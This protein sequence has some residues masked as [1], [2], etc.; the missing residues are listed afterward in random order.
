MPQLD[1]SSFSS[2]LFWLTLSFVVL[3]VVLAR[4]LLPRVQSVF[5]L[6]KQTIEGDI[7]HAEDMESEASRVRD[8]YEK[9]LAQARDKSKT[10]IADTKASI[11]ATSSEKQA[12]IDLIIE[13][14]MTESEAGI[15]TAKQA[16]KGKLLPVAAELAESIV[17]IVVNH[18]P[19]AKELDLAM[20]QFTEKEK[21]VA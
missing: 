15:K 3:Y 13:R 11:A 10:I 6:R 17:E 18:K 1:P 4:F 9:T 7:K 12:E 2:Q 16:V 14:K 20:S 8:A 5:D 21:S 19:N